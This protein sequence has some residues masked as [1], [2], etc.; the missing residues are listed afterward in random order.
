MNNDLATAIIVGL[1][2]L[3]A[4]SLA[5]LSG[6][7]NPTMR[8]HPLYLRVCACIWGAAF[9]ARSVQ[10]MTMSKHVATVESGHINTL[11]LI[12]SMGLGLWIGAMIIHLTSEKATEQTWQRRNWIVKRIMEHPEETPIMVKN[13]EVID[14]ARADGAA[15][16]SGMSEPIE[17]FMEGPRYGRAVRRAAKAAAE[18]AQA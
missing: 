4:F 9:M 14:I 5:T 15:A 10:L 8:T 17:A 13:A 12:A 18:R 11:G 16:V 2:A 1:I 6:P 3:G 7:D